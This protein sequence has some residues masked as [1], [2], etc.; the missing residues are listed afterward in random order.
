MILTSWLWLLRPSA[1]LAADLA[2]GRTDDRATAPTGQDTV[3]YQIFPDRFAA[4]PRV[5]SP[6]AWSRGRRLQTRHG[7]KGGDL[8]GSSSDWTT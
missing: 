3:F 8:L 6:P 2:A 7:L 1:D 5:A 4:S